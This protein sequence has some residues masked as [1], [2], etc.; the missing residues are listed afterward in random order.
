MYTRV[1][2]KVEKEEYEVGIQT[3]RV[4][5]KTKVIEVAIPGN[6]DEP[7]ACLSKCNPVSYPPAFRSSNDSIFQLGGPFGCPRQ[8]H[9]TPAGVTF[10]SYSLSCPETVVLARAEVTTDVQHLVG[11]LVL[12]GPRD[13]VPYF[14]VHQTEGFYSGNTGCSCTPHCVVSHESDIKDLLSITHVIVPRPRV[15]SIRACSESEEEESFLSTFYKSSNL[16]TVVKPGFTT[17]SVGDLTPLIASR[18]SWAL[19]S[20][21]AEDSDEFRGEWDRRPAGAAAWGAPA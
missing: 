19:A 21:G 2:N 17:F 7:C 8:V 20:G 10:C 4:F 16:W 9:E 12:G 3:I 18:T 14:Q 5:R 13:L 15:A 11:S 6:L 1:T